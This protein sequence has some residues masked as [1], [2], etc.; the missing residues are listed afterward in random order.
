MYV[1]C[2]PTNMVLIESHLVYKPL[3]KRVAHLNLLKGT[4]TPTTLQPFTCI[5]A[6]SQAHS[7]RD[8]P[9]WAVSILSKLNGLSRAMGYL[10]CYSMIF[11]EQV[12][13]LTKSQIEQNMSM[14]YS[15]LNDIYTGAKS[16][17]NKGKGKRQQDPQLQAVMNELERHKGTGFPPHPKMDRLK[18][19][20]YQ[21][22]IGD[23]AGDGQQEH[24]SRVMVFAT[25]RDT[26]NEIVE[27]MN[28]SQPTI[29]AHRFV[30][31]GTD[32]QSRKGFTQ[33][34]Q[35]EVT[36]LFVFLISPVLNYHLP[37]LGH[38]K[39]QERGI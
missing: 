34:E 15:T 39:I 29:R 14:C 24:G 26:V 7:R 6:I 5:D 19:I 37:Q 12:F 35:L 36:P 28:E 2:L 25:Y 30:G 23:A 13:Q 22:F 20:L 10:V 9:I 16:S 27:T 32:K 8:K 4:P 11:S 17:G 3:I 31:Q 33:K 1:A 38:T 18:A 21:H